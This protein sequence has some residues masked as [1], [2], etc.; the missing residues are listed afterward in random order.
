MTE[1]SRTDGIPES[2]LSKSTM[3]AKKNHKEIHT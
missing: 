1:F 2:W 3:K